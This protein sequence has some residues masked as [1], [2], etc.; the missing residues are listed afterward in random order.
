M[1]TLIVLLLCVLVVRALATHRAGRPASGSALAVV[2]GWA[3]EVVDGA[4]TLARLDRPAGET[5]TA[6]LDLTTSRPRSA[7]GRPAE[8]IALPDGRPDDGDSS[9]SRSGAGIRV[10]YLVIL[11]CSRS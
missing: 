8:P 1:G 2:Q 6:P 7:E 11:G 4:R 3:T 5:S 10:D 9:R